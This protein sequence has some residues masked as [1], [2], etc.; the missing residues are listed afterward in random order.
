MCSKRF[1]VEAVWHSQDRETNEHWTIK[2]HR[3][4]GETESVYIESLS[5]ESMEGVTSE[6]RPHFP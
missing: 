5:G 6:L 2:T 1:T 4:D 3:E